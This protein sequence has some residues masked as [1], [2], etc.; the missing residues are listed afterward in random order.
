MTDQPR[1]MPLPAPSEHTLTDRQRQVL[2]LLRQH[3]AG[4]TATQIAGELDL[5]PK[6][7]ATNARRI[8]VALKSGDHVF[9][10]RYGIW[11]AKRGVNDGKHDPSTAPIGF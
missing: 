7:G 3:P 2:A 6:Y 8:L 4:L 10:R 9:Q 1:L 11:Q 5:G